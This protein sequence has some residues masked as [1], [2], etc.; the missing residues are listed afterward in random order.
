MSFG[1]YRWILP[2]WSQTKLARAHVPRQSTHGCGG[3]VI[4]SPLLLVTV[5]IAYNVETLVQDLS[6]YMT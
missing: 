2:V 6:S 5:E 3:Y 4:K 1:S